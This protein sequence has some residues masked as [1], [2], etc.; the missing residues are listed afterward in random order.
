MFCL[1]DVQLEQEHVFLIL[2]IGCYLKP[3]LYHVSV[4]KQ[5]AMHGWASARG[6]LSRVILFSPEVG[7]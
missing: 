1:Y 4:L 7:E 3:T 5:D 2:E 6:A